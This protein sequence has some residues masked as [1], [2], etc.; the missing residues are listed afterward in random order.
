MARPAEDVVAM[1]LVLASPDLYDST[2]AGMVVLA[3]VGVSLRNLCAAFSTDNGFAVARP[4]SR[5]W[6]AQ[7]RD[8]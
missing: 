2:T 5:M 3:P 6:S 7:S 8:S 4:E 1:M